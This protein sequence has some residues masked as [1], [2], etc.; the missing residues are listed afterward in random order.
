MFEYTVRV[1]YRMASRFPAPSPVSTHSTLVTV[2][3]TNAPD[4]RRAAIDAA[5]ADKSLGEI[6]H[7]VPRILSSTNPE[8][9]NA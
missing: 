4:A 7:A 8:E 5:Y 2:R 9:V 3:A 1:D 6:E